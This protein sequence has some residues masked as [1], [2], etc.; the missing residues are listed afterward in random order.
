MGGEKHSGRD[1][2]ITPLRWSPAMI[3]FM[4]D[5]HD[6]RVWHL[7]REL[8]L[9]VIESLPLGSTRKVPGL[10][11]QAIRAANSIHENL[12]EGCRCATRPGFLHFVEI[13]LASL[14]ELESQLEL[15]RDA[16]VISVAVYLRLQ[17]DIA[18]LRRMLLALIRT[19]KRRISEDENP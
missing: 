7:A 18:M 3:G 13:A 12:S 17:R 4:Q 10:R 16:G 8:S 11:N 1:E 6:L 2:R 9:K 5:P 14:S 19:L 15:A